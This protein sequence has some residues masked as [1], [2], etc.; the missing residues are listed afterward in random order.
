MLRL[1]TRGTLESKIQRLIAG[2]RELAD[3]LIQEDEASI[4]KHLDRRELA[5][6]VRLAP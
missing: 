2:K 6:P 4:I 5:E 3:A 1:I